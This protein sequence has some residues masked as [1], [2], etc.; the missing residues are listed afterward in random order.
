M[1][2]VSISPEIIIIQ[3]N[4]AL[5]TVK[6]LAQNEN[7][8]ALRLFNQ[9]RYSI[10]PINFTLQA[11]QEQIVEVTAKESLGRDTEDFVYLKGNNYDKKI[12]IKK[13]ALEDSV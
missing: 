11:Q 9:Q 13:Y 7:N 6:N 2:L 1:S 10:E 8:F 12:K 5:F 4:Q 3:N